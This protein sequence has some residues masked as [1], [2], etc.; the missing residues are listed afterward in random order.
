MNGKTHEK[1][2]SRC[3]SLN[4]TSHVNFFSE[5]K[6]VL[7]VYQLNNDIKAFNGAHK[8]FTEKFNLIMEMAHNEER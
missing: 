7:L 5:A 8:I 4:E 3:K 2:Q 6:R 1:H